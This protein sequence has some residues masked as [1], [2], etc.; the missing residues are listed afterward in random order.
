M[1]ISV[2]FFFIFLAS[3]VLI[4]AGS[5][6]QVMNCNNKKQNTEQHRTNLALVGCEVGVLSSD[7]ILP[8]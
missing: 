7:Y 6:F 1:K 4:Q 2:R 5:F 3:V 8:Q